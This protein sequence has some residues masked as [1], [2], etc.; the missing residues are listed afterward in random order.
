MSA[1]LRICVQNKPLTALQNKKDI[2][3]SYA[4]VYLR[5]GYIKKQDCEVCGSINSQMHHDDYDKPVVVRWFCRKH[6]ISL[7]LEEPGRKANL[8]SGGA[9]P[10]IGFRDIVNLMHKPYFL[11][12][13]K[14]STKPVTTVV[15]SDTD[16]DYLKPFH[17]TVC[18][19]TVFE[20][21]GRQEILIPGQPEGV[22]IGN[23]IIECHGML[24][25]YK[26]G[27]RINTR[28]NTRYFV[29]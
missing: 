17:C 19:K 16:E 15:L 27:Q 5:K 18:G 11:I 20:Y 7:H 28:C 26:N 1:T 2:A 24:T 12:K 4:G 23:K 9:Q 14:S 13:Q 25:V 21:K 10:L 6:H 22:S 29:T 8:Q 3:R